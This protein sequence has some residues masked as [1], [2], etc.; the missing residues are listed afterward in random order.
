M[1][2]YL[3]KYLIKELEKLPHIKIYNKNCD[4]SNVTINMTGV[5]SGDLGLYLNSKKICVRSGKHCAKMINNN[6]LINITTNKPQT[7]IK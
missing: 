4:G 2:K 3:R 5:L 6:V 1:A 7:D